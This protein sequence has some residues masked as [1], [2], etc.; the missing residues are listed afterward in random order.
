[1]IGEMATIDLT[2]HDRGRNT[3][4]KGEI[5]VIGLLRRRHPMSIEN[6]IRGDHEGQRKGVRMARKPSRADDQDRLPQ[7]RIL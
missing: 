5:V 1:M 6:E 4:A 2:D 7:T 3:A